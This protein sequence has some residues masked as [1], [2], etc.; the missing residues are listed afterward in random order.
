MSDTEKSGT[1]GS[2]PVKKIEPGEILQ[3]LD[4]QVSG[5]QKAAGQELSPLQFVGF[6][7]AVGVF[8]YIIAATAIIFYVSFWRMQLAP[9]PTPPVNSGD[10]EHYKQLVEA[11]K[12]SAEV[13][14]QMA[15]AQVERATQLFQLVVAS[16]ILPAFTAILGYIFGS[17]RSTNP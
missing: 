13:Y 4:N 16:T 8:S 2:D 17:K 7:L 11:Y 5:T 14:Q 3:S 12:T 1:E 15:K 10:V 9:S 6:W